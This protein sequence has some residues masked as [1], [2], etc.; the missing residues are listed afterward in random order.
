MTHSRIHSE[1]SSFAKRVHVLLGDL[2]LTDLN[3]RKQNGD[4][5]SYI[6]KQRG[7]FSL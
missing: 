5:R 6:E 7:V 3:R 4:S 2:R 1:Y